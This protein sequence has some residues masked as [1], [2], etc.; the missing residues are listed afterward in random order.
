[1]S[2][3]KIITNYQDCLNYFKEY[4]LNKLLDLYKKIC[5][6][7]I[8]YLTTNNLSDAY[9]IFESLNFK[10]V[11]LNFLDLM[12]IVYLKTKNADYKK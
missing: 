11:P 9:L 4:E 7:K 1:M 6:T 10:G 3:K 2:S 8:I 12:K 5:N